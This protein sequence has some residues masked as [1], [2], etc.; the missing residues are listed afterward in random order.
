M[1][2]LRSSKCTETLYKNY[3]YKNNIILK[4]HPLS[5][6]LILFLKGIRDFFY[7]RSFIFMRSDL[8]NLNY[9]IHNYYKLNFNNALLRSLTGRATRQQGMLGPSVAD[10]AQI[11]NRICAKKVSL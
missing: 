7:Y 2:F 9:I 3:L 10:V 4:R 5:G 6:G 8:E 11:T 1:I